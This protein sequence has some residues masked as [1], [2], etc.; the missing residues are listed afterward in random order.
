MITHVQIDHTLFKI[1]L[2]FGNKILPKPY[3]LVLHNTKSYV[4]N[5]WDVISRTF[6]YLF[7]L[8]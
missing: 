7:K 1:Q 2:P 4:W 8:V 6:F 3:P 5:V